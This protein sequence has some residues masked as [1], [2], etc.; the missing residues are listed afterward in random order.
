MRTLRTTLVA[1]V[2]LVLGSHVAYGQVYRI[3]RDPP[4]R[5]SVEL[6]GGGMWGQGFETDRSTAQ[7]TRS[8]Q[9]TTFDL[10]DVAGEVNGF[11]GAYARLG[12]YL[13]R[14]VSIEAGLRFAKPELAYTLS[15]D[16]ESA[17]NE[18]ATDKITHYLF[19][20]SVLLHFPQAAFGGGRGVPFVSAGAGYLRE[21]HEGNTV[22]ETGTAIHVTAGV[23]YWFGTR[24]R[25][26]GLR[27]EAG[28]SSRE[29]GFD[30]NDGRR[31][32]PF[33]LGGVTVLY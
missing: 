29:K 12:V 18:I 17:R 25:R 24:G 1:S 15:G 28:I 2:M 7:L 20:G 3:R 27:V 21:L 19:D 23:K 5:G 33:V 9:Q 4:V 32:L 8:G 22:V 10:F 14:T 6:G 30:T 16:A 26:A 11:P 13:S 31:T